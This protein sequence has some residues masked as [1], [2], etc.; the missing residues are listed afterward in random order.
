MLLERYLS[1]VAI[2]VVLQYIG[3]L[4]MDFISR[5][6]RKLLIRNNCYFNLTEHVKMKNVEEWWRHLHSEKKKKP[7]RL[8]L[9]SLFLLWQNLSTYTTKLFWCMQV[10]THT[11]ACFIND[12]YTLIHTRITICAR[13]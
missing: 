12:T 6:S 7:F 2:N 3:P 5:C 1:F 13:T 9:G 4:Q 10:F 11:C 8:L